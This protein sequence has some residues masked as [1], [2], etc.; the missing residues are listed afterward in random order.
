M[1]V[2]EDLLLVIIVKR[3]S[4]TRWFFI[5]YM[6]FLFYLYGCLWDAALWE[7]TPPLL[8]QLKRRNISMGAVEH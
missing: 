2:A 6:K 1:N 8:K 3:F 4:S 7:G 5:Y